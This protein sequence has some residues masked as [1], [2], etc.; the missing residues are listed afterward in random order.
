VRIVSLCPFATDILARFGVG[1]DLVGVTHLCEVPA[2][3]SKAVVVTGKEPH[4]SAE[5]LEDSAK[6][7]EGLSQFSLNASGLVDL[8][9]DVIIA[10]L[11][12]PKPDEFVAWAEAYLRNATGRKVT[13]MNVAIHSLEGVYQVVEEV[14]KLA[15]EGAEARKLA[16]KIKAQLMAWADSFFDRCKGKKV[17]VLSSLSPVVAFQGWIPDLVKLIGARSIDRDPTKAHVP[18]SWD[19]VVLARPDVIIVAP[20][21]MPLTESV[22]TVMLVQDL[23]SWE[24]LPAVKRGEVIF[25]AGTD[26]YRPGPRFLKGAAILVSAVAGLDSGFITERDEYFKV[27]Y[28][29]L[30]R[31]RFM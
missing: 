23:P 10:S 26:I 31:H 19:E 29:E 25:C 21:N 24:D 3:S 6:L 13:V 12:M 20:E 9:P 22:K 17:V 18:C 14:G 7:A 1:W 2:S 16:S 5:R 15:G 27:R 28:L 8:I 4:K 30:H 11:S